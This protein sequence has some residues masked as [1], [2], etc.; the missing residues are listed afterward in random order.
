MESGANLLQ[1]AKKA[2]CKLTTLNGFESV[3]EDAE[4][5]N[6]TEATAVISNETAAALST[7]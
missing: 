4:A 6:K 2:I 5:T 3:P 1:A 7:Y